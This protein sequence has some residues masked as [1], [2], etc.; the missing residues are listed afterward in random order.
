MALSGPYDFAVIENCD[1]PR[2]FIY[3]I[4]LG[5]EVM[6]LGTSLGEQIVIERVCE[7]LNAYVAEYGEF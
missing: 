1:N 7:T 6:T 3:H 5:V 4:D 2:S